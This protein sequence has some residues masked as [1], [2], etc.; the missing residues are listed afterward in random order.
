MQRDEDCQGEEADKQESRQQ[1]AAAVRRHTY[2]N[3]SHPP[4]CRT[5]LR[6]AIEGVV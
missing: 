1:H 2:E 6:Q 5:T 4:R 3:G